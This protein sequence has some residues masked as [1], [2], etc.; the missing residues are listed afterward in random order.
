MINL[1]TEVPDE[2]SCEKYASRAKPY[3]AE[4][5]ATKR[6][7]NNADESKQADR[8]CDRL[9]FMKVEKPAHPLATGAAAFT[10]AL[11]PGA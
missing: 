2:N 8:M 9:S 6:H 10:S 5:E 4:L 3:A 1:F 7:P 11:A